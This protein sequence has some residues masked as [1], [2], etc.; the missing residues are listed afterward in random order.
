MQVYS[1]FELKSS[2]RLDTKVLGYDSLAELVLLGTQLNVSLSEEPEGSGRLRLV[3]EKPQQ[4]L[5]PRAGYAGG[6][7]QAVLCYTLCLVSS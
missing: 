5:N 7:L 3:R 4:D 2:H 6:L 1:D